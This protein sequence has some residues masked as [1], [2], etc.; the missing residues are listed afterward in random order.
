MGAKAVVLQNNNQNGFDMQDSFHSQNYANKNRHVSSTE[1]RGVEG[2]E[3][4]RIH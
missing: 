1:E 4:M 3:N 2:Q